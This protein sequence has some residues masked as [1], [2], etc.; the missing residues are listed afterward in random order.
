MGVAA[1]KVGAVVLEPVM[2]RIEN[3]KNRAARLGIEAEAGTVE[4][5]R[6]HLAQTWCMVENRGA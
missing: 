6:E 2:G 1:E 3:M 5:I 4:E